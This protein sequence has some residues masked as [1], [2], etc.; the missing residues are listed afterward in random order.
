MC[1]PKDTVCA[2][3]TF[4]IPGIRT[5]TCGFHPIT[6]TYM[7]LMYE[8]CG[9]CFFTPHGTMSLIPLDVCIGCYFLLPS[10]IANNRHTIFG[11]QLQFEQHLCCFQF[12]TILCKVIVNNGV[13]VLFDHM[14]LLLQGIAPECTT[15]W[16]YDNCVL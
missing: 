9:D 6:V 1:F 16:F 13:H 14:F 3:R 10:N 12:M 5:S 4:R 8:V 11:N 2:P 15:A 7:V